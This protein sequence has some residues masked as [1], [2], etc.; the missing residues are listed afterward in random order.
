MGKGL[1]FYCLITCVA[2]V[3]NLIVLS[4]YWQ[5]SARVECILPYS[6]ICCFFSYHEGYMT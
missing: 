1:E 4:K 3:Q 5:S 2:D 6:L